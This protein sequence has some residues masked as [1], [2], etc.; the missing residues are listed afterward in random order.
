MEIYLSVKRVCVC[1]KSWV[2]FDGNHFLSSVLDLIRV[3]KPSS[4]LPLSPLSPS[5]PP[6]FCISSADYLSLSTRYLKSLK[7][8]G[9][10]WGDGRVNWLRIFLNVVMKIF[11]QVVLIHDCVSAHICL[12]TISAVFHSLL[13]TFW[14]NS[15]SKYSCQSCVLIVRSRL[16]VHGLHWACI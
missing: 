7:W 15:V 10:F 14:K 1:V 6:L 3:W 13:E 2:R 8:L 4:P 12:P 9:I 11:Q 16:C 5:T